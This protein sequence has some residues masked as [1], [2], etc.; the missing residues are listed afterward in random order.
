MADAIALILDKI[1]PSAPKRNSR[2]TTD[3]SDV[4]FSDVKKSLAD[5]SDKTRENRAKVKD[6]KDNEP[7]EMD[8]IEKER[9]FEADKADN[10][11]NEISSDKTDNRNEDSKEESK[12]SEES[13][14]GTNLN[15]PIQIAGETVNLNVNISKIISEALAGGDASAANGNTSEND[16]LAAVNQAES[17]LTTGNNT[18][19]EQGTVQ[20]V[21]TA[22]VV[23][24]SNA[25]NALQNAQAQAAEASITTPNTVDT[26]NQLDLNSIKSHELGDL[27]MTPK[28]SAVSPTV[29]KISDLIANGRLFSE[30]L[31]VKAVQTETASPITTVIPSAVTTEGSVAA[32]INAVEKNEVNTGADHFKLA[33]DSEMDS[34]VR[35]LSRKL[36]NITKLGEDTSGGLQNLSNM[37][38]IETAK[39]ASQIE[40]FEVP[41]T[42]F[43]EV[44]VSKIKEH[45]TD[46]SEGQTSMKITVTPP[47]LG[48]I[49]VDLSMKDGVLNADFRCSGDTAKVI[50]ESLPDL[51]KGLSDCGIQLGNS[52]VSGG[53]QQSS[54]NERQNAP[55]Y[56]NTNDN[57]DSDISESI[58]V[59]TAATAPDARELNLLV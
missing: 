12:S 45:F 36:E 16:P 1:A 32:I 24:S 19:E 42:K 21:N 27:V 56:H 49:K 54:N 23:Q 13:N 48:E 40:S 38:F 44:L 35:D 55:H 9:Q 46:K 29:E 59:N 37:S 25:A 30:G 57:N 6:H 3:K 41:Q 17:L 8:R 51:Q 28:S 2:E 39:A 26:K 22:Q 15:I 43:T 50:N 31:N 52:S 53:W 10:S 11:N 5:R 7:T 58:A 14:A 18:G 20:L 33:F 47:N 34:F 4:S